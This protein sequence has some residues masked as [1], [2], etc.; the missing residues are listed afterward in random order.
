MKA[1]HFSVLGFKLLSGAVLFGMLL[2]IINSI[3]GYRHFKK[4][5]EAQYNRM[6]ME[7]AY[8]A[9]SYIDGNLVD[10]YL[11]SQYQ[12]EKWKDTYAKLSELVNV[13]NL[14]SLAITVPDTIRYNLQEYVYH[15]VNARLMER[16]QKFELGDP[17]MLTNRDKKTIVMD[18]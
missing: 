5:F 3:V 17:E 10:D 14:E 11:N 1:K 9:A 6:T 8:I 18:N 12:D 13:A 2:C 7:F 16:S 15:C 4:V